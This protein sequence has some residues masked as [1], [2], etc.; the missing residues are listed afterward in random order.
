[1]SDVPAEGAAAPRLRMDPRIRERRVAVRRDEGRR[2]LRLVLAAAGVVAAVALAYGVTRT[3]LLD[4]DEVR[5]VGAVRTTTDDVRLAGGLADRPQ[6]ADVEPSE[7]AVL[8]ERLPWVQEA[9]VVRH[10]PG[11]VEVALVERTAVAALPAAAG[12]W[13]VVDTSGRVLAI[14]PA[15]PEG[16][17]QVAAPPAPGPGEQV[18]L[19]VRSSLVVLDA[20]P[21][22]LS[23]RVNGI[24]LAADGTLDLHA[25]GL[26]IIRFGPPDQVRPKLVALATLAARTDLRGVDAIDVRVPTAPVLTGR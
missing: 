15:A 17:V 24:T 4:V 1:M 9:E 7:V 14:E 23:A 22:S 11:T 6:L 5:V 13:A 18:A 21:P 19:A 26:P 3:P 12:G 8:V 16:M 25:M 10:W 2:R 20:L